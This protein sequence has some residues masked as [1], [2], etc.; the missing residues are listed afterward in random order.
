MNDRTMEEVRV[1]LGDRSYTVF[2]DPSLFGNGLA[3]GILSPHLRGRRVLLVADSNTAPLYADRVLAAANESGAVSTGLYVIPAGEEHKTFSTA[4]AICCEAV[5]QGLDRDS[6]FLALGGGV[7]TDLTGFAASIYMRGVS[8]VSIPTSL[9][10]MIDAAIG[11]KT[12]ADLP[13]GK[14][15][16]GTFWQ[17]K[18][19]LMDIA[20]LRSLPE[21]ERRCG[22][23]EL[24]KH[25]ILFDPEL[26][27]RL[28]RSPSG[29]LQLGDPAYAARLI[30]RSCR[31]KASVVS[32][33]E[34]ESG[35]RALLNFG[36]T[37]GHAAERLKNFTMSH[38]EAVAYGMAAA[39]ELAVELG[40]LS[41]GEAL[42]I[43]ELIRNFGLPLSVSGLSPAV[44]LE[45]M[46]SDKKNRAGKIRLVLPCGIGRADIF[47]D[48]PD[49]MILRVIEAHCD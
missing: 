1:E 4:E 31:L 21:K 47:P 14:N 9:L 3:P 24:V 35:R 45:S 23:A 26:F 32:G 44:I 28:E 29:F 16:I 39:T 15:L 27:A 25:A 20:F 33:D 49:E 19:V 22:A 36:H 43:R 42:R 7:T 6:V 41:G 48:V 40:L 38:G 11:G 10:A 17:P 13:L 34:R 5:R 46:R 2:I 8:F 18:A 30:A 12:G 37:F